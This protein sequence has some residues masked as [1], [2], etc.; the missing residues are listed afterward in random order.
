MTLT[1]ASPALFVLQAPSIKDNLW[2]LS[3]QAL[4]RLKLSKVLSDLM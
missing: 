1:K 2:A 3:Y 4:T